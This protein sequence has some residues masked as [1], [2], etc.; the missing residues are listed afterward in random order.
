VYLLIEY[1]SRFNFD[2]DIYIRYRYYFLTRVLPKIKKQIMSN[3]QRITHLVN[4]FWNKTATVEERRELLDYF[5]KHHTELKD[6]ME[7]EFHL[8]KEEFSNIHL[9]EKRSSE[10]F[11]SIKKTT[12]IND[13]KPQPLVARRIKPLIQLSAAAILL[14]FLTWSAYQI[15]IIVPPSV[16]ISD[17]ENLASST[18][19][20]VYQTNDG[21]H[22]QKIV[23]EDGSIV[24]LYPGS[25]LSYH[26]H[27]DA[28]ARNLDLEGL[29]KFEVAKDSL[30]PFTVL[31]NGYTTTALGTVFII[32]T[33]EA[34]MVKVNLLSG[35]VVVRSTVSS[36]LTL[37]D[38]Y[39]HPGD[40]LA[41]NLSAGNW[42][43]HNTTT[44]DNLTQGKLVSAKPKIINS[45]D[46]LIFN[47]T[48]LEEVFAKIGKKYGYSIHIQEANITNLSFTG[49]FKETDSLSTIMNIICTMNDLV[50]HKEEDKLRITKK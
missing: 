18:T 17:K 23:L 13:I 9:S 16:S 41:I 12:G 46:I 4:K 6:Q 49:N 1:Q 43:V 2:A 8:L 42:A 29:A 37:E 10:L 48:P 30:R 35:K 24:T 25:T 19:E 40:E 33:K 15:F 7:K 11:Q 44:S 22:E 39:L 28:H 26:T 36:R 50:Y 38:T 47:K 31:A 27:F 5:E 34:D 20:I 21:E 14:F 32:N 45:E 3:M